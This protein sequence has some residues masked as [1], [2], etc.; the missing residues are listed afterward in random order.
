MRREGHLGNAERGEELLAQDDART[1]LVRVHKHI[2]KS[3]AQ[4]RHWG[5]VGVPEA[6]DDS[7]AINDGEVVGHEVNTDGLRRMDRTF[8]DAGEHRGQHPFHFVA[9]LADCP[10]RIDHHDV[11]D[12][13]LRDR[14]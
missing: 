1:S 11:R 2:R 7:F 13:D 9:P 3:V 14:G 4:G 12:E 5:A 6:P 8:A 10:E